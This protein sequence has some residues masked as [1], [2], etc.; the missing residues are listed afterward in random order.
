MRS[1]LTWNLFIPPVQPTDRKFIKILSAL[2]NTSANIAA[3]TKILTKL[4]K[5]ILKITPE[6]TQKPVDSIANTL[7]SLVNMY[8]CYKK[9]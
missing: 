7:Q 2:L 3:N 4:S 1:G 9:Y 6:N 8:G 5:G